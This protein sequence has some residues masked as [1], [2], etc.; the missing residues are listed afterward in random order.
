VEK[1]ELKRNKCPGCGYEQNI[2]IWR[3]F[4]RF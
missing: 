2:V 4:L 1:I 3:M